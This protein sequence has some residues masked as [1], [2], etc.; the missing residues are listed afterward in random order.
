MLCTEPP[1]RF[2]RP[3]EQGLDDRA[4]KLAA[5]SARL[6][7]EYR[8]CIIGRGCLHGADVPRS[9]GYVPHEAQHSGFQSAEVEVDA[10][11]DVG[12][13]KPVSGR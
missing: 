13:Q 10:A 7:P 6:T 3:I 5:M 11:R 9:P 8:P 2:E 4:L 1:R 12:R